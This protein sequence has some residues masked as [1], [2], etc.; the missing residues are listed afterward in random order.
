MKTSNSQTRE[1]QANNMKAR[2]PN[3]NKAIH[4]K[5]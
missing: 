3:E 5:Q 2:E 1:K 4:K